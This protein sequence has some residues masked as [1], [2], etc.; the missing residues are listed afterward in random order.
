[1]KEGIHPKYK[2]I[3]R[4]TAGAVSH[5]NYSVW[6]ATSGCIA[7]RPKLKGIP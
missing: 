3:L 1:M 4:L 2:N 5:V 6:C 7:M